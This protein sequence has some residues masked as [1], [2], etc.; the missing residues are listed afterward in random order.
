MVKQMNND[1]LQALVETGAVG[2]ACVVWFIA[3]L[4]RQAFKQITNWTHHWDGALRV[5]A[6]FASCAVSTNFSAPWNEKP[7][8]RRSVISFRTQGSLEPSEAGE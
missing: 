8:A 7:C 2:S 1:Y 6:F 3:V 5:A 4:D